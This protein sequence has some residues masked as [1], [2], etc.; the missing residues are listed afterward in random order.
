[1]ESEAPLVN[2]DASVLAPTV[3][4]VPLGHQVWGQTRPPLVSSYFLC[5]PQV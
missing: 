3:T 1:M 4:S 2:G 5:E